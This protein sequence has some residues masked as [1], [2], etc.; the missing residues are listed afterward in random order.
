MLYGSEIDE[1]RFL[2]IYGFSFLRIPFR[3][4]IRNALFDILK[5]LKTIVCI[6]KPPTT[7]IL[8]FV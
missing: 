5:I 2:K 3:I 8:V 4:H 6:S 7:F 1:S